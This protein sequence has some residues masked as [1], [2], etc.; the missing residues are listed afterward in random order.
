MIDIVDFYKNKVVQWN[1]ENKCGFC[2]EFGAPLFN[3]EI[4]IQQQKSD[5]C[6]VNVFIVNFRYRTVYT[7]Q[8][9]AGY[10]IAD[11]NI[12][13]FDLYLLTKS[14]LGINNYNEISGHPIEESKWETIFKPLLDCFGVGKNQCEEM[15]GFIGYQKWEAGLVHNYL[16]SV[17]N[18]IK[19]SVE[20]E[21]KV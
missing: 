12:I 4:N 13:S 2:Y 20:V 11:K 3:S 15:V 6:C 10:R 19:I 1:A 17:Y 5:N 18:G 8:A 14:Q 9:N 21:T 16:D 7:L